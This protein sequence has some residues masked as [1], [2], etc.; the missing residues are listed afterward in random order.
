MR[1]LILGGTL[2][3][4]RHLVDAARARGHEVTLFNRG[5]TNPALFPDLETLRGDRDGKLEPLKGR[6]WDA[7]IDT[8][9]YVPRVVK[10][11]A[12]LLSDAVAHTTFISSGSVYADISQPGIDE[13]A[14]VQ[15]ARDETSENVAEEYGALKALCERA[16]EEA[17]P[18]RVLSVRAGLIV[19]PHDPTGR[20]PYWPRRIARGGEVLAPGR[21]DRPI[22]MIDARDLAE[23]IVRMAEVRRAGTY[24]ATGP[25]KTLAME[26]LLETCRSVCRPEAAREARFVWV[27]ERFL[28]DHEVEPFTEMP[29]WLPESVNGMLRMN[30][31]RAIGSGLTFRP[32][33]ETVA[34]TLEWDR[35]R[36]AQDR[37]GPRRL[38]SGA[39][40]RGGMSP[41]RERALLEAWRSAQGTADD[42]REV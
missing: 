26:D 30:V 23:W 20:F 39:T 31:S 3:L 11:S 33:A 22:Q 40:A 6:R 25:E 18:G 21:P 1:I 16:L 29:L 13:A 35:M 41:E 12:R 15:K 24:N 28:L 14:T 17:M 5:L 34:D 37:D 42:R 38:A 10:S 27:D 36:S 7:A 9:G 19:G 2:F 4:G 32:L 8:S